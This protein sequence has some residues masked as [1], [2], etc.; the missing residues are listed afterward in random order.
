MAFQAEAMQLAT[1]DS[2]TDLVHADV[3]PNGNSYSITTIG[4]C[5]LALLDQKH[6]VEP[7]WCCVWFGDFIVLNSKVKKVSP[8]IALPKQERM[9]DRGRAHPQCK[10]PQCKV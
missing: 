1:R 2:D 8:G 4:L 7:T 10:A 5:P 3:S 6:S 9:S